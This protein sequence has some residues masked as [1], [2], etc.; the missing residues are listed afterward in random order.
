MSRTLLNPLSFLKQ[1]ASNSRDS[2]S[3]M[4]HCVGGERKREQ[5][6]QKLIAACLGMPSV[7]S[8]LFKEVS[9]QFVR[10]AVRLSPPLRAD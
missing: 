7:M 1:M 2:S 4:T 9:Q 6:L 8:M 5:P 3:Q 10:P